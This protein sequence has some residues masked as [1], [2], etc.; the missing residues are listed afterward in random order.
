M[1]KTASQKARAKASRKSKNNNN[2]QSSKPRQGKASSNPVKVQSSGAQLISQPARRISVQRTYFKVIGEQTFKGHACLKVRGRDFITT[3]AFTTTMVAGQTVVNVMLCPTLGPFANTRLSRY[4]SMYEKYLFTNLVVAVDSGAGSSVNGSY[5]IAYDRDPS[6]DTPVT[7]DQGLREFF[8]M[9]GTQPFQAGVS[10]SV[11]F[12]LSDTQDFYYTNPGDSGVS[13]ERLYSQGQFYIAIGPQV[14]SANISCGIY[15]DWEILLF[16]PELG[17]LVSEG[18]QNISAYTPSN[19]P[20]QAWPAA[21][22]LFSQIGE[23]IAQIN[24][25]TNTYKGWRLDPGTYLLEQMFANNTAIQTLLQPVM[26]A[27]DPSKQ[28]LLTSN[29]LDNVAS[30]AGGTAYRSERLNVPVGGANIFGSVTASTANTGALVRIINA[31]INN[32][33]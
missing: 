12:P 19:T 10:G 31:A 20:A 15:L 7:G 21:S 11:S 27:L 2:N 4:C 3:A 25:V 32:I 30:I 17:S 16:D 5:L 1:T 29:V 23:G 8:A 13:D 14:F 24:D 28:S 33:F 26:T 6:D 22:N 9:D 18:K